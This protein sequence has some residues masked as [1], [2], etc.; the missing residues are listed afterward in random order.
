MSI[1]KTTWELPANST[2]FALSATK[3]AQESSGLM[4][5]VGTDRQSLERIAHACRFFAPDL[6]ILSF[7]DWETLPYDQF[8]PHPDIVAERLAILA[9]LPHLTKGIVLIPA[10]TLAQRLAPQQFLMGHTFALRKGEILVIDNL[11]QQLEFCGYHHVSQV[12]EPGEYAVR[13]SVFDLFPMGSHLPIRIDLFDNEIDTIR[14]FDP[15]TQRSES[16]QDSIEILPA[17]EFPLTEEAIKLFRKHWREQFTENTYDASIYKDISARNLPPGIEYYLPLFFTNTGTLFDYLTPK[18]TFIFYGDTTQSLDQFWKELNERYSQL[19]HD[20]DRPVLAPDQL[21][22]P[23]NEVYQQ[24]KNFNQIRVKLT[25]EPTKFPSLVINHKLSQPLALLKDFLEKNTNKRILFS[26]DSTGRREAL[27]GL[28]KSIQYTPKIYDTWQDFLQDSSVINGIQQMISPR[29]LRERSHLPQ[30]EA[31]EGYPK[32]AATL[33]ISVAAID[34]GTFL[35]DSNVII[36]AE[37]QLYAEK[38]RQ[39]RRYKRRGAY[40]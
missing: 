24:A 19:A 39:Q 3:A 33:G 38:I 13:G 20:R 32:G 31:G 17:R 30:G 21:F 36:I 14:T 34:N 4:V 7:P 40:D 23:T 1:D 8:S 11:R 29:P 2:I 22:L 26:C 18:S 35:E 15:E 12:L 9:K 28:L 6:P 10:P 25:A 37:S 5:L 16:I 27:L